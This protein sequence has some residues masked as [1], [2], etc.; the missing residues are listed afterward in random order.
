MKERWLVFVV[1]VTSL[2]VGVLS[3]NTVLG[4]APVHAQGNGWSDP[5]WL[6]TN[7]PSSWFPDV[8]ADSQGRV[9]VVWDSAYPPKGPD[10]SGVGTTMYAVRRDGEWSEPNDIA[11]HLPSGVSRPALAVDGMDRLHMVLRGG[12]VRYTQAP[13]AD[14]WSAQAWWPSHRVSGLN[15]TYTPD[16]VVDGKGMVHVV[17]EEWVP[18]ELSPEEIFLQRRSPYLADVFYR[19]SPDG[20]RH[21]DPPVNLSNTPN[22]GSGRVHI[23][24]DGGG[25]I[26]VGWDEGWDRTSLE[27][28][29]E[30]VAYVHSLDGG[31][32]WSEPLIFTETTDTYAQMT[33]ETNGTD[34]VLLVWR[35][36]TSNRLLYAWSA[37]R[38]VT[39]SDP[40]PIPG[41]FARP[42]IS[43]F[44]AYDMATDGSGNIHLVAVGASAVPTPTTPLA[45]YHLAWNGE[46]WSYP[47]IVAWYPGPENPEWPRIAVEGGRRLHVVWF[48]RP[49][50][51]SSEGVQVWYS[52]RDLGLEIT[53]AP[54]WTPTAT[55]PSPPSPTPPPGLH[56]ITPTP[57]PETFA[58][59]P[60]ESLYTE[61]D[62][63]QRLGIAL[64][65]VVGLLVAVGVVLLRRR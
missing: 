17:W 57:M 46:R 37:D 47:E 15:T 10:D 26:H 50:G 28:E 52:E 20:G 24:L 29:P 7:T 41:I 1:V 23:A 63:L 33:V 4:S 16:L 5:V 19:R 18:V 54:T 48:T 38:G 56:A 13:A 59:S 34:G 6:S 36:L 49:E 55:P 2:A 44:D 51:V 60:V 8:A 12:G 43:P 9:H 31:T 27:G 61:M 22:V 42:W 32:T 25:G 3:L 64:L 21:W 65:P 14:A 62:D 35:T 11:T 39:F 45:L 58:P 30:A 53:P 40:R